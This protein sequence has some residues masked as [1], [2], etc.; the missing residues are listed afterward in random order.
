VNDYLALVRDEPLR[1]DPGTQWEYSNT[2]FL[3]LGAVIE[4]VT[5]QDYFTYVR[6]QLYEPLGM[7]RTDAYE[8]D[9]ANWNL[10]VGYDKEFTD[11]GVRFRNNLF[12]HVI[13]GGP[14]GGGHST[15]GDLVRFATALHTYRILSPAT[16]ELLLTPKPH[17]P[18]YGYGFSIDPARNI[19]G[20]GGG[21]SGIST[22]LDIFRDSGYIAVVLANY[23]RAGE[24]VVAKL[25]ELI[26]R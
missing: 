17:S 15:V 12:E 5:G 19:V 13:R 9:Q 20:H 26:G 24:P 16:T 23:G 25:R 4:A 3:L 8:L 18:A 22:N 14:A 6:T 2:G 21:F 1:F 11:A 7:G 10:A